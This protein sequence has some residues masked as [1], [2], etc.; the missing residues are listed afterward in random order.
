[1]SFLKQMKMG[2]ERQHPLK[3]HCFLM[4]LDA[5]EQSLLFVQSVLYLAFSGDQSNSISYFSWIILYHI[6]TT[7]DFS[8]TLVKTRAKAKPVPL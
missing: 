5:R 1:M 7:L 6:C 3:S 2:L 8:K 4:F